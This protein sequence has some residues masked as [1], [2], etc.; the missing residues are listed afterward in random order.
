MEQPV[1]EHRLVGGLQAHAPGDHGTVRQSAQ[2]GETPH[3]G[4]GGDHDDE[5]QADQRTGRS[6]DDQVEVSHS[7]SSGMLSPHR[8]RMAAC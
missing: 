7:S 1:L 6:A 4:N 8:S 3:D 2:A 5:L